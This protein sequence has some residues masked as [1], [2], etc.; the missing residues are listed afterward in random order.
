MLTVDHTIITTH[1][2][3][4]LFLLSRIKHWAWLIKQSVQVG[5][6]DDKT[7]R[8]LVTF[9]TIFAMLIL[10]STVIHMILDV[11]NGIKSEQVACEEE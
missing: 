5:Y 1:V 2:A 3:K 8:G 9:I 11:D 7:A 4:N 10:F 6:G